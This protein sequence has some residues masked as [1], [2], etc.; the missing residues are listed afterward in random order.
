[1][2]LVCTYED[3]PSAMPGL[4]LLARS[5]LDHAPD[6]TLLCF[7]P[8]EE[9]VALAARLPNLDVRGLDT[10]AARGWSV[11]PEV[12]LRALDEADQALWLDTDVIVIGDLSGLLVALPE[13]AVTVGEEYHDPQPGGCANRAR[14]WGLNVRRELHWMVNSGSVRVTQAHRPLLEKW[15]ALLTDA[16]FAEAQRLPVANRPTHLVGDQDVLAALLVSDF[17]DLPVHYIRNGTDMLQH[18]G[19]NGYH[20]MDRIKAIKGAQPAFVHMLGRY[21]PWSFATV[22]DLRQARAEYFNLV[23]FELSPFHAAAAP[24]AGELGNPAWLRRRTWPARILNVLAGG[25]VALRGMPL[26]LAAWGAEYVRGGPP[27]L[28]G[29]D[30]TAKPKVTA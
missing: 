26:A 9:A 16:R 19:A 20:V 5:L 30:G 7:S 14:A 1:M 24:Y 18:C 29:A 17:A 28:P 4:E 13:D 12:L 10:I 21:K 22:P 3:R 6:L 2:T 25:N 23:C 8:C 11:K 27:P 15:R